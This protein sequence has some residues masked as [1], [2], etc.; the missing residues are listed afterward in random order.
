[1]SCQTLIPD[2][3]NKSESAQ[4]QSQGHFIEKQ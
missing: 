2:L 4:E 1:M 3:N